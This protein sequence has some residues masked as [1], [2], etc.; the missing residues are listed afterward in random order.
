MNWKTSPDPRYEEHNQRIDQT[1]RV[2]G[3]V[4]PASGIEGRITSRL[5]H[6]RSKAAIASGGRLFTM[7]RFSMPRFAFGAAAAVACVA[8]VA[9]SVSHSRRI[10]P[11]A[12]GA[13]LRLPEGSSGIGAA[14]A[15]HVATQ[16]VSPAGPGRSVRQLPGGRA[17]ISPQAQRH[18]GVAVPKTPSPEPGA[19]P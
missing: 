12:P 19:Q 10:L 5:A 11:T 9:G 1:L 16:P 18:A 14:S 13:G 2:L 8:I 7:P 4:E 15:A 6:E 17:V 3:S